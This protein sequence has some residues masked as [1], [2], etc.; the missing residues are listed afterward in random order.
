MSLLKQSKWQGEKR[1]AGEQKRGRIPRSWLKLYCLP[2]RIGKSFRIFSFGQKKKKKGWHFHYLWHRYAKWFSK[3]ITV[4]FSYIYHN[5]THIGLHWH[6]SRYRYSEGWSITRIDCLEF[7]C[8][9]GLLCC[10]NIKIY[11]ELPIILA[12]KRKDW[13]RDREEMGKKP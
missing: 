9:M 2:F 10:N 1:S 3:N 6:T 4:M 8:W 7:L 13:A 12:S 5:M 11:E